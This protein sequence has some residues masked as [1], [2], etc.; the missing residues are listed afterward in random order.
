MKFLRH[1]LHFYATAVAAFYV[2]LSGVPFAGAAEYRVGGLGDGINKNGTGQSPSGSIQKAAD[3][4]SPG[5]TIGV[6]P[7]TYGS[8]S[9]AGLPAADTAFTIQRTGGGGAETTGTAGTGTTKPAGFSMTRNNG[10]HRS[11]ALFDCGI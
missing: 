7:G 2:S 5:G 8:F 9:P 6:G 1:M 10:I 3:V 11:F 4:N